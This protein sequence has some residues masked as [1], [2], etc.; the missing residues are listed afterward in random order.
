MVLFRGHRRKLGDAVTA[1]SKA[2]HTVT[3][4]TTN[5]VDKTVARVCIFTLGLVIYV[6]FYFQMGYTFKHTFYGI[7]AHTSYFISI[8]LSVPVNLFASCCVQG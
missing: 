3:P 1:D 4:G 8:F 7:R 2:G 5:T 6:E